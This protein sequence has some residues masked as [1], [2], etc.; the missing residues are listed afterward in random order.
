MPLQIRFTDIDIFGH[1]NNAIYA[2]WFDTARFTFVKT[3]LP[4]LDPKGKCMV[5]VHLETNFRKQILFGDKVEIETRIA[6]IGN[7]SVGISQQIVNLETGDIHADSYGIVSTYDAAVQAS[8][9]MPDSWRAKLEAAR[10][11]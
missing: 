11:L 3:V 10:A 9:P 5:M 4:E 7:R 8:I 1:V 2:E 6:K